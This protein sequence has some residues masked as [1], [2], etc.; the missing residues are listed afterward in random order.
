M[1]E[2]GAE[3]EGAARLHFADHVVFLKEREVMAGDEV[4]VVD[5][6]WSVDRFFAEAEMRYG[7]RAGFF[8]VIDEVGLGKVFGG[9]ADDL[10]RVFVGADGAVRAEAEEHRFVGAF[11]GGA[12]AGVVVKAAV[13]YVFFDANDEVVFRFGFFEVV[14]HRFCHGRGEFLGT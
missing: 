2:G 6:V 13:G 12:E 4:G 10:D 8:G 3:Q 11:H 1:L 7:D 14:Q 9:F 5:Q